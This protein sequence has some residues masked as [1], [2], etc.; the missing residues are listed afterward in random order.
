M[1]PSPTKD[2]GVFQYTDRARQ[3]VSFCDIVLPNGIT[4]TDSDGEIEYRNKAWIFFELKHR[5]K[6]LPYGQKLAFERKCDDIRQCGKEVI[7]F[8]AEHYV[9]DVMTNV[10]AATC[11]VRDIYYRGGWAKGDGSDL[12]T[13]IDRF[14][15]YID[16]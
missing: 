16:K 2:R 11:K 9:D 13:Y 12:K 5:D 4:P 1:I 6:E 7:L 8:V 14:I 15:G 3:L 10:N